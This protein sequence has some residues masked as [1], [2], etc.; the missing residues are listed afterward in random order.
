MPTVLG[1]QI[2]RWLFAKTRSIT[3]FCMCACV[4]GT[5]A[6][7]QTRIAFAFSVSQ[8]SQL[9]NS[10]TIDAATYGSAFNVAAR[11]KRIEKLGRG[12]KRGPD[13]VFRPIQPLSRLCL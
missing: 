2:R 11:N 9:C 1:G 10:S 13:W 6:A 5:K 12:L 8:S 4:F 3:A 7:T